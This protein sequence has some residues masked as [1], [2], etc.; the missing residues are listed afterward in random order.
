MKDPTANATVAATAAAGAT[1]ATA[2]I[3]D[4]AADLISDLTVFQ[5]P[6]SSRLSMRK[7]ALA[8]AIVSAA[9]LGALMIIGI[10]CSQDAMRPD[11]AARNLAPSP[12]HW[13]GTDWLGRDMLLRTLAGLSTSVGVGLL[14]TLCSSVI[15]L[16]LS[17]IAA[18]GGRHAD[19]VVSWLIDLLLGVPHLVLLILISY[20]L[21]KGIVG[22]AAGIALTH[23]PSL[24][25][26]LR[27]ELLQMRTSGAVAVAMKLGQSRFM[28]A[29]KH[30]LPAL[31]P[32]LFVGTVLT[33]PHAVLHEA[34]VTFLGFGLPPDIPSIG[35]ILSEAMGFLAIGDWWL[36]VFP[37]LIL[38]GVVALFYGL[39]ASLRILV[40]PH[41][42]QR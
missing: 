19:G 35:G 16:V 12:A 31:Q 3:A 34:S 33:F 5:R 2:A 6:S 22:V 40:D 37:G 11:F 26:V 17:L 30:F 13:F 1:A 24:T 9:L 18:W 25:R 14:A 7:A 27:A 29:R 42:S 28:I 21:G 32:Q 10:C 15:A 4:P 23:W 41:S 36:A 8:L 38:V 20:A 39:G